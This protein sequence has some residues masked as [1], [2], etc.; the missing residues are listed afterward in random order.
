MKLPFQRDAAARLKAETA[1]S[2]T[3]AAKLAELRQEREKILHGDVDNL[4]GVV[5]ADA[6]VAAQEQIVRIHQE[7]LAGLN[8]EMAREQ[9][10][11][12]LRRKEAA[13]AAQEKNQRAFADAASD[14]ER[15][16]A[17]FADVYRR[18]EQA[19][20][21]FETPWPADLFPA[22]TGV[23]K[24][25]GGGNVMDQIAN[26]LSR[27]RVR[28]NGND[29]ITYLVN[30]VEGLGEKAIANGKELIAKLR[31]APLPAAPEADEEA[32]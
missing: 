18:Y 25:I 24:Y 19:R 6:A 23:W 1:A 10:A 13:L 7:R 31:A 17:E 22:R 32:A 14:L 11:E 15:V 12:R 8:R 3:A 16:G 4:A 20:S 30:D 5:A 28:M 29:L 2:A 26:Q 27:R 9:H 21:L